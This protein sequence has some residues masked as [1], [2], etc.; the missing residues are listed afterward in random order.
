MQTEI[1]AALASV[2]GRLYRERPAFDRAL[3]AAWTQ[4]ALKLPTPLRRAI[5]EA[6]SERDDGAAICRNKQGQPEPDKERRDYE[7]VPLPEDVETSEQAVRDYFACQ[8]L[9]HVPDAWIDESYRDP[10][11]GHL[12]MVGYEINFNRYFY[13]YQ[14]PRALEAIEADIRA[15]EA[16]IGGMLGGLLG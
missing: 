15:L 12:G 13:R 10:Q 11:D 4:A 6:L 2:P 7:N 9:P 3:N 5:R 8:V 16:E 1:M 14:P